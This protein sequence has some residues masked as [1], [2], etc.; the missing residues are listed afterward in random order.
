[1]S[2]QIKLFGLRLVAADGIVVSRADRSVVDI[3][4]VIDLRRLGLFGFGRRLGLGGS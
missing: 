4:G 3:L 1:M 2:K